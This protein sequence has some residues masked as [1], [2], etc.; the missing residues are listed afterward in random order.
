LAGAIVGAAC[1]LLALAAFRL[2]LP[3][4]EKINAPVVKFLDRRA[5]KILK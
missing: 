2:V 3:L 5:P 1:A 4:Y